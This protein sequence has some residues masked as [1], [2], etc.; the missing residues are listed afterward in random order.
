MTAMSM[1][2]ARTNHADERETCGGVF[3]LVKRGTRKPGKPF[4]SVWL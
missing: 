4:S 3:I 2:F 1:V